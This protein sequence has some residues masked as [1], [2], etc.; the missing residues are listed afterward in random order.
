[1]L[2]VRQQLPKGYYPML[3]LASPE[4]KVWGVRKHIPVGLGYLAAVLRG[5]PRSHDLRRRHR[6]CNVDYY[7]DKAEARRP[8]T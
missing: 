3:I 5:R 8:T 6:D 2:G 1:M 4:A 7:L